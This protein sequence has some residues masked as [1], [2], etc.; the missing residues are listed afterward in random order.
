MD[1]RLEEW[2]RG[3]TGSLSPEAMGLPVVARSRDSSSKKSS[4][5]DF[6]GASPKGKGL[7]FPVVLS[8]SPLD[9]LPLEVED[10]Q[11]SASEIELKVDAAADLRI[12]LT[13]TVEDV[14]FGPVPE[15]VD[16]SDEYEEIEPDRKEP[17]PKPE[18][19]KFE[20][21]E[22]DSPLEPDDVSFEQRGPGTLEPDILVRKKEDEILFG[23]PDKNFN[24]TA[25]HKV[26]KSKPA[27][28][29][30]KYRK[31][32]ISLA[33]SLLLALGV[34]SFYLIGNS[35]DR[36][37]LSAEDNFSKG[38]L[39]KALELYEKVE[40]KVPLSVS[41]LLKKGDILA[42]KGR[43]AE[44]LDA[45]YGALSIEPESA[46]IHRK[47]ADTFFVLGSLNQAEKA[48]GEVLR[49]QPNNLAVREVLVNL[50]VD[51]GDL[52]GALALLEGLTP[53][54]SSDKIDSLRLEILAQLPPVE[55]SLDLPFAAISDDFVSADIMLSAD[56]DPVFVEVP[57]E[58]LTTEPN[59]GIS[60]DVLS[61]D[62]K[63]VK[64]TPIKRPTPVVKRPSED[65]KKNPD[66]EDVAR[67]TGIIS[68]GRN[69]GLQDAQALKRLSETEGS[70]FTLYNLGQRYNQAGR[71]R[72]AMVFLEKALVKDSDNRWILAEVA[73]SSAS[74]G[75]DE[76]ALALM[77]QALLKGKGIVPNGNPPSILVPTP[78]SVWDIGW[79]V[80]NGLTEEIS[81]YRSDTTIPGLSQPKLRSNRYVSLQEAI[82]VNPRDRSL[83]VG[84]MA[85]YS[86]KGEAVPPSY[87]EALA[88]GMEA[89]ARYSRGDFNGGRVLLQ[90]ALKIAPDLP[91]LRELR[92]MSEK[93]V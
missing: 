28:D 55:I 67:F 18:P 5:L 64:R 71:P 23:E 13:K 6:M 21:E 65:S 41:S 76:E 9:Q 16:V 80:G 14:L 62:V 33:L 43:E 53:D 1:K 20:P 39:D 70:E 30:R 81:L 84:M 75:R 93:V 47:V 52:D 92:R 4:P 8:E 42:L 60:D 78:S 11:K 3:P 37:L 83:Y 17:K 79:D 63:V 25:E 34:G 88:I 51:R 87:A 36:Q 54:K 82:N 66:K 15:E 58:I 85:L 49:L 40:G 12:D 89:H 35:V 90:K 31:T 68:S 72:E 10:G 32:R 48:Y 77:E 44:A 38:N 69:M 86:R 74:V 91:F 24:P 57:V 19:E 46:D 59:L 29:R 45:Y 27:V 22:T 7:E 2:F 61:D 56:L 26:S 50:K 73:Y